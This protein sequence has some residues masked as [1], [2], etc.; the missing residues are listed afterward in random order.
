MK[1]LNRKRNC[2]TKSVDFRKNLDSGKNLIQQG[3]VQRRIGDVGLDV[4]TVKGFVMQH[5]Y[6]K[7]IF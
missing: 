7:Y 6:E 4:G 5:R 2:K 1:I 3:L